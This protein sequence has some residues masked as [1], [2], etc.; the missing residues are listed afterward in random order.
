MSSRCAILPACLLYVRYPRYLSDSSAARHTTTLARLR[1]GLRRARSWRAGLRGAL[2]VCVRVCVVVVA[3]VFASAAW[4]AC[5]R[6][7]AV[8]RAQS[9]SR[10]GRDEQAAAL[11]REHIAAAPDDV[12]ARRLLVR[13]LGVTGDL[14]GARA[15]AEEIARIQGPGDPTAYIEL[16][17]ALELAHRY[18]EALDAYDQAA[19][20]APASPA[21]PREGGLRCAR[22]G[23][24]DA[25]RSRLEE[26]V[27]RGAADAET[28]HA[29]GL[30]RLHLGD[31]DGADQAY[32][33]GAAA[34]PRGIDGA[35][36][37]LGLATVAI[38]RGDAAAAL[39][40]YDQVVARRPRFA[41]AELGRAWAL[42]KLGRIDEAASA[43]DRAADLGASPAIV[44]RQRAALADQRRPGGG[45]TGGAGTPG[46]AGE[47]ADGDAGSK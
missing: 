41:S 22:W 13:L 16:G 21:G 7:T 25:A 27:R 3:C 14:P 45:S 4:V 29:L 24:L 30:V 5:A 40:A 6:P 32:R 35:E 10:Q 28:W 9:L 38:A 43:L 33:A 37:W 1:A 39:A 47:G 19:T 18:D 44:A 42:A 12:P 23:E 34:D 31:Y 20:V 11:L 46:G 8:Q 36:N 2:G 26:A 17:H 15:Q